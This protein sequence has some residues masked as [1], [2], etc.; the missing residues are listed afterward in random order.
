MFPS[1]KAPCLATVALSP[2]TL[3]EL[4]KHSDP[5]AAERDLKGQPRTL[6]AWMMIKVCSSLQSTQIFGC[7]QAPY[8]PGL[9]VLPWRS[10]VDA[11]W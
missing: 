10:R 9:R 11:V 2:Q 1:N 5:A 7:M 4:V 6:K 8:Q 3:Q